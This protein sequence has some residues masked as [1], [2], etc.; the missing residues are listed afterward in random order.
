MSVN[1]AFRVPLFDG[2]RTK[3]QVADATKSVEIAGLRYRAVLEQKRARVRDLIGRLASGRERCDLAARRATLVRERV[4]LADLSLQAQRGSLAEAVA[5]RDAF[6]RDAATAVD[7]RYDRVQ[8]WGDL[9][10]ESGRLAQVVLGEHPDP[11]PT[12]TP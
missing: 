2:N 8:T 10:L 12:A 11:Q 7:A 9:L 6:G 1:V 3:Y 4:R 5:A